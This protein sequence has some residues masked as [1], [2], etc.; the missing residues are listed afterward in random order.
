ML[1]TGT[2]IRP[3]VFNNIK[4]L[5]DYDPSAGFGLFMYARNVTRIS[6]DVVGIG[7]TTGGIRYA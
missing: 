4:L 1:P 5:F 2:N 3:M 6:W 7:V